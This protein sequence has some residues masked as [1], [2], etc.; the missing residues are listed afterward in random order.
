MIITKKK[1]KEEDIESVKNTQILSKITKQKEKEAVKNI[2]DKQFG[3]SKVNDILT[4]GYQIGDISKSILGETESIN[5][6]GSLMNK[7]KEVGSRELT[8]LMAGKG[9]YI[10]SAK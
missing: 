9:D 4:N 2:A 6:I 3:L 8:D 7:G 1:K 10:K 5:P